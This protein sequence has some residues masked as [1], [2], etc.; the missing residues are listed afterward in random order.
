MKRRPP[1]WRKGQRVRLTEKG[2]RAGLQGRSKSRLGV[3][4]SVRA[5][6]L[7]V[8]RDGIKQAECYADDFWEAV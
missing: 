3:V 5:G 4:T 6:W 1:E 8:R 2:V 7:A